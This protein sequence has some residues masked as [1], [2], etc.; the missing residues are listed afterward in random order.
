MTGQT[1]T[2]PARRM[3]RPPVAISATTADSKSEVIAEVAPAP[4][5]GSKLALVIRLLERAEGAS[6]DEMVAHTS[7]LHHSTR[8]A[9]TGLRKKGWVITRVKCDD[10]TRYFI[11]GYAA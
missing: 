10:A 6:L 7:W 11:A 1:T 2:K 9:L 3:A 4:R 5:R 8:A